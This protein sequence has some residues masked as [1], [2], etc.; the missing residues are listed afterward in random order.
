MF[1]Q[2]L[3]LLG[4]HTFQVVALGTALVGGIGAAFG[5]F[6]VLRRQS[7]FGDAIAHA[8]LP[9]VV[10]AFLVMQNRAPLTLLIGAIASGLAGALFID[11]ITTH[12]RIKSDAALGLVLAVFFGFGIV[13]LATVQRLPLANKAG[14]DKFIFGNAAAMLK[15]DVRLIA[16]TTL[17]LMLFLLL[18]WKELKCLL[19]DPHF[20]ASL[21][22]PVP[23]LR[24]ALTFTLV[25]AICIGLQ[26][27]G[28]V[29]MSAV[30]I[31]PA[32]AARQWTRSLSGMVAG[33]ALI[34]IASSLGGV[35][36]SSYWNHTPTG[37]TIVLY[38]SGC[39]LVSL[40]F[41]PRRGIFR[42]RRR[43]NHA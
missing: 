15:A 41:A 18:F 35:I 37:P 4:D 13:L 7:L 6:A 28:A 27:V 39:F 30:I 23:V 12:S 8:T 24:F 2:F 9:G 36:T 16:W 20:L 33:A 31:A 42:S 10:L 1:E 17:G 22:Y 19:F 40:L 29:L 21:G 5:C 25:I 3:A 14:L 32:N 38:V 43:A 26:S 34:G 11:L